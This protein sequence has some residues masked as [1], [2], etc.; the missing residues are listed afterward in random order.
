MH[1]THLNLSEFRSVRSL[2]LA[3]PPEG[4]GLVGA[5]AAG[6][7]TIFEAIILLAT[8]RSTRAGVERELL[9]WK[10]GEDLQ[11]AP[12]ARVEGTFSSTRGTRTIEIGFQAEPLHSTRVRKVIALDGKR[13]TAGRVVGALKCVLF[14]PQDIDLIAGSPG[15]RRR[16]LDVMLSQIDHGYLTALSRY[17]R[18]VEQRNSLIKRL[19]REGM[20]WQDP[21]VRTELDYWD[22]ELIAHGARIIHRRVRAID[23]LDRFARDRFAAFTGI[24]SMLTAYQPSL[25]GS[26]PDE[27]R[28]SQFIRSA[29]DGESEVA[30]AMAEQ[31]KQVRGLEF[32]RS[33]TLIGPH[34]DDLTVRVE[35]I[36]VGTFGSRGQQRLAAVA[37][38]LAEA[39]LMFAEGG[40]QPIVLL[41][42]V[43]SELDRNHRAQLS[44]S[45]GDLGAQVIVSATERATLQESGLSLAAIGTIQSG[46]FSWVAE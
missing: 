3:I 36:D 8:T 28:M 35:G 24:D 20:S 1:L 41:D 2:D 13:T 40:D 6:K 4:F 33:V 25:G 23:D 19:V 38:K 26:T 27:T 17:G 21:S 46:E 39:D 11:V 5:N 29:R 7:S 37:L 31:L 44:A 43:Y 12:Y 34:R 10:S 9:N 16:F 18:I 32:K 30:F 42:D 15:L 22:N 14:E 45:I